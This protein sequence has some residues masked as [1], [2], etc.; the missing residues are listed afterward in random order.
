MLFK[1]NKYMG[2]N[3]FMTFFYEKHAKRLITENMKI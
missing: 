1:R 2:V 3:S